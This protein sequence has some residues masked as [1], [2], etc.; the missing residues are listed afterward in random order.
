V[1]A[2]LHPQIETYLEQLTPQ[3]T[4]VL[5]EMEARADTED[6]PIVGPLVGRLL[7]VLANASRA[8][9][10]FEL[11]SGFGYSGLWFAS[12][13]PASGSITLTDTSS[14]RAQQAHSYFARAR[15]ERKLKFLVGDG[16]KLLEEAQGPWDIIFV[17][18]DKK[19]YPEAF[20]LSLRKLRVGG[21]LIADNVLW[22]GKVIEETA[23]AETFSIKRFGRLLYSTPTV[24]SS[25]IPLRDGVSISVKLA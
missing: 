10:I 4:A 6:F 25:I 21:L 20:E 3:S 9:K 24:A 13:L 15:Q 23:D 7:A 2:I 17:D 1:I 12:A 18:M 11:G 8:R 22:F 14:E 19:R 5:R 16:L